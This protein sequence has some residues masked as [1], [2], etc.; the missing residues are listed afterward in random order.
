MLEEVLQYLHN[1]FCRYEDIVFGT[2]T[3][4]GG[5]INLSLSDGQYFRICGSDFNDGVHIY[6]AGDL[7]DETFYGS[8]WPLKIPPALLALVDEIEAWQ[9]K[10]GDAAA[11]PY[12]SESF[13]GYSYSKGST[14]SGTVTSWLDVFETRLSAWRKV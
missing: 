4:A 11:G 5:D 12:S 1:W 13:G 7:T 2:F 9:K 3:I 10:Y 8:V 14:S 6:Q